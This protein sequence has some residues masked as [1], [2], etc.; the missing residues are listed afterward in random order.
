[1]PAISASAINPAL[2]E[3]DPRGRPAPAASAAGSA[4]CA[5][6]GYT[7]IDVPE[8]RQALV[9][10]HAGAEELG[11]VYRPTLAINATPNG[12][13]SQLEVVHPPV[14]IPWSEETR[15]ANASYRAWSEPKPREVAGVE[16][17]EVLRI[18][19][20]RLPAD[21]ILTNGA[22]NYAG[23]LHRYHRFRRP[24]TQLAPTSGSMGYGVPAAVAA[25]LRHP[26]RIVI[27]FAGDGCFQMTG[28]EFGTAAQEGAAILVILVDNGM[29]GTIR[30]HQERN[31]PDASRRRSWSI[32]ISPP[33]PGPMAVMARRW[34]GPEISCRPS[35]ARLP[36]ASRR[37]CT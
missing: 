23:W 25:K 5:S 28:Q 36:A 19:R 11:R 37:S 29:Y 18:L 2:G 22:G 1:M 9:H 33:S 8:P 6:S 4:R 14:S 30:A 24:G 15:A 13:A 10:V 16:M 21:A 27:A 31:Y 7:L 35:N 34:S 26:E 17:G 3:A 32:R 20:E 12:F